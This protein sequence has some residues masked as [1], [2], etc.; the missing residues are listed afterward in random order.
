MNVKY[1]FYFWGPLLFKT[2][3]S[4]EDLQKIK[5]LCKKNPKRSHV[6]RLAGHIDD[7]YTI[8]EKKVNKIIWH[9][10]NAFR[11]A[12]FKWY[13]RPVNEIIA[14]QAWVNYMKAG[15]FNPVHVH[16]G[17]NFSSVLYL[18]IPKKLQKEIKE[19]KGTSEGPGSISFMFGEVGQFYNSWHSFK[20]EAGDMYIFPFSLRHYVNAFKSK[21]ERVSIAINFIEKGGFYDTK[22]KHTNI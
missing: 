3:L 16:N 19:Y 8:D 12:F 10:T 14:D 5:K 18:D 6:E 2:K 7:E 22:D 17:C 20:P 11:D 9:Y 21:C 13:N 1:N 15:D 4:K